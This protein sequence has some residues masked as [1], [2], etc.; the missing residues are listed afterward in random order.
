VVIDEFTSVVDRQIA[1]IGASA[2]SKAWRKTKGKQI[3]LL[4]CH[5]DIV[6]WL[7]PDW[8]YDTRT[9]EVKKKPQND[10]LLNST[11]GRST[12]VTGS[13]LNRIII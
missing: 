8:V 7:Q 4:S 2:F 13:F 5:Y 11:F 6:E 1:K 3:V 10:R 9:G 12:E